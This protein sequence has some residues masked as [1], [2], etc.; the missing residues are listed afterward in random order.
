MPMVACS[1]AGSNDVGFFL[2][3]QLQ[4]FMDSF[5]GHFLVCEMNLRCATFDTGLLSLKLE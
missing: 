1:V 2:F 3:K 4:F 5:D